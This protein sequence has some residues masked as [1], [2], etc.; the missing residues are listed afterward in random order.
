[1]KQRKVC[2]SNQ[3]PKLFTLPSCAVTVSNMAIKQHIHFKLELSSSQQQQQDESSRMWCCDIWW[4][5]TSC[6]EE[7]AASIMYP[8]STK[9]CWITPKK[10]VTFLSVLISKSK[11]HNLHTYFLHKYFNGPVKD[12]FLVRETSYKGNVSLVQFLD[13]LLCVCNEQHKHKSSIIC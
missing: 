2:T 12:N 5:D 10:T 6:L 13:T 7:D 8:T 3:V 1:M 9:E 11:V 4:M